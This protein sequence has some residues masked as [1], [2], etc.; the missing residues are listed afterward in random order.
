MAYLRDR[1]AF[2]NIGTR[3]FRGARFGD[4][5]SPRGPQY[6]KEGL[7]LDYSTDVGPFTIID[8]SGQDNTAT[9]YSGRGLTMDGVSDLIDFGS[10]TFSEPVT[11]VTGYARSTDT[12]INLGLASATLAGN[13]TWETFSAD[14]AAKDYGDAQWFNGVDT[15]VDTGAKLFTATGD[16]DTE[17]EYLATA[18]PLANLSMLNQY[19]AS[20]SGRLNVSHKTDGTIEFFING[21]TSVAL[22]SAAISSGET[23][24]IRV[25]RIG[26]LF[27]LYVDDNLEDSATRSGIS[28]YQGANTWI[29]KIFFTGF[30]RYINGLVFD[31]NINGVAAYTGRGATPWTDTIGSNDGTVSGVDQTVTEYFTN[32]D[33][34][35]GTGYNGDLSDIRCLGATGTVLGHWTLADWSNPAGNT[36]NGKT[37][38]D[39]GPNGY[40]GTCT[41]CSGF[42]GE[43]IDPEVA[44][45]VGY[46]DAQWFNGVDTSITTATPVF[47]ATADF[48]ETL[49]IYVGNLTA[50]ASYFYYMSQVGS[51]SNFGLAIAPTTGIITFLMAGIAI[52]SATPHYGEHITVR[53]TR[54]G[55]TFEM[56]INGVSEGTYVSA[57]SID[58]V[59][60]VFGKNATV[61]GRN[62]TG[63]IQGDS[64]TGTPSGTFVTVGQKRATIPQTADKNW[65]KVASLVQAINASPASIG[66]DT[67]ST[68][69]LGFVG[70]MA[71]GVGIAGWNLPASVGL[72]E[73][74]TVRFFATFDESPLL[75][76][77]QGT[78]PLTAGA[79]ASDN[80]AVISGYNEITLTATAT[81]LSFTFSEGD[82]PS[83]IG[84]TNIS[85]EYLDAPSENTQLVSASDA[86]DQIDALGN[87]IL[88]PRRNTQQINLF[89]EGE[90]SRT[91]DSASL[92]LTTEATW[93]LW[94]NFYGPSVNNFDGIFAKYFA[95]TGGRSWAITKKSGTAADVVRMYFGDSTGAAPSFLEFQVPDKVVHLLIT[96][97][98]G[99]VKVYVD[100]VDT[101]VTGTAP[102]A[103]YV[104]EYPITL[105]GYNDGNP[106]DSKIGSAKIYNRA[107]TA[108]EVLTNYD[109][110]KSLYL[111]VF[112]FTLT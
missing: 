74:V 87:A 73:R 48:D 104:S 59:A 2:G 36:S 90:Y 32:P 38:V 13:D 86:N 88:E 55:T 29:G 85:V 106:F 51:G 8:Q 79:A 50:P 19:E 91:P 58:Q 56:L 17:L 46:D 39:S 77:R 82:S 95:A 31:I 18:T 41:G 63:I 7:I 15:G 1:R 16:F 44:G 35:L 10:P 40:H 43:G 47:P 27:S 49:E 20:G 12:S 93:E 6:T 111:N 66:W 81:A 25:T 100:T 34:I 68:T 92:D 45:I 9:L 14:T 52:Q 37:I 78:L 60:T 26:D 53:L 64:V 97:S 98:L 109:T 30:E 65:N 101:T 75:Q 70:S 108:E 67:F 21:T 3:K 5:L 99:T 62:I 28:I 96:F 110:Q 112:P 84:I 105:G 89:G 24:S 54:V 61:A 103:I 83:S 4:P 80:I 94:G 69:P 102:S 22:Q 107:L 76:L 72:G 42:T 71:A 23:H 33:F 57:N 11:S